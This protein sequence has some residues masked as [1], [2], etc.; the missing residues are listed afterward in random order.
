MD[1]HNLWPQPLN[2][3]WTDKAKDQLEGSVC[4]QVC[5]GDITLNEGQAIFLEPDWTKEH[6]KF[7][8]RQ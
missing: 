1:P 4:H 8:K 7:F 5:R 3:K 6:E 2:G